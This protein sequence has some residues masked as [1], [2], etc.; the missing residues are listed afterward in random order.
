MKLNQKKTKVMIFNWTDNYQFTTKLKLNEEDIE[1]ID[2]TKLLGVMISNDL[3]WEKNTQYLVQKAN[4]RMEL[5]RKVASFTT[6]MEEKKEI[7]ILYIRS[8]LEQSCV[9]WN[10]SLTEENCDDLE[11]VQ[12]AAVRV[13]VGKNYT[14][15]E[16]ALLKADLEPLKIRRDKLSK[17]F[18]EK[19]LQSEHEP[20]KKMFPRNKKKHIMKIRDSEKF[21]VNHANTLRL[22]QSSIP[23]MQRLL[24]NN[25]NNYIS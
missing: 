16:N 9:V 8:I 11:R 18:A 13:I 12:K 10:S 6:S 1:V 3:K 20:T 22:Q 15:Y 24:N 17:T 21:Q 7:Y 4:K 25:N 19:C 2:E 14:N 5:L 23:F